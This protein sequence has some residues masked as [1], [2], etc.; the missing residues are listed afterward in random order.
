MVKSRILGNLPPSLHNFVLRRRAKFSYQLQG[1]L[2]YITTSFISLEKCWNTW[3]LALFLQRIFISYYT[4]ILEVK[5][6]CMRMFHIFRSA[7]LNFTKMLSA[8]VCRHVK[9]SSDLFVLLS[10]LPLPRLRDFSASFIWFQGIHVHSNCAH[11]FLWCIISVVNLREMRNIID[12]LWRSFTAAF[13]ESNSY[14]PVD[15]QKLHLR[16]S[17]QCLRTDLLKSG[18][19]WPRL[20][21]RP[22]KPQTHLVP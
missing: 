13:L 16:K 21:P 15:G 17:H 5:K 22:P 20:E 6:L 2:P 14:R 4:L 9:S 1:L 18:F 7:I 19:R 3:K 11:Y 10:A 12:L 8:C